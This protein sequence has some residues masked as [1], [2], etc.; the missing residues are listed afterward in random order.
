MKSMKPAIMKYGIRDNSNKKTMTSDPIHR[1][2]EEQALKEIDN[3]KRDTINILFKAAATFAYS[4]GKLNLI[5]NR[6]S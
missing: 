6:R 5:L 1:W 2:A 3:P 4:S